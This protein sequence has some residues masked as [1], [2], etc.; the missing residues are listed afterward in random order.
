MP[1]VAVSTLF[2]AI[3]IIHVLRTG[4]DMRWI[5][6]ILFVPGIG[7]AIY[8]VMEVLPSLNQ[9]MTARRAYLTGKGL[10]EIQ[11]AEF[12]GGGGRY[13]Y[14]DTTPQLGVQLELLEWANDKDV[15][16]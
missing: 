9:N 10:T 6:L 11:S 1:L 12:D 16:S 14:F 3:A 5:M 15:Q 7:A 13:A 8:F 2:T 4:R